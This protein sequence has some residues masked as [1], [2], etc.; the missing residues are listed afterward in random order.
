MVSEQTRLESVRAII[1][2]ER[3]ERAAELIDQYY[4]GQQGRAPTPAAQWLDEKAQRL[5]DYPLSDADQDTQDMLSDML[6]ET[7]GYVAPVG[8]PNL[9]IKRKGTW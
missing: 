5:P 6:D 9:P 7:I 3:S 1:L 8:H 2:S 4:M